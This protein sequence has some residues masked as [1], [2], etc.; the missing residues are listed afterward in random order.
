[1]GSSQVSATC[2]VGSDEFLI[3]QSVR[4]QLDAAGDPA[5]AVS[6]VGPSEFGPEHVLSLASPDLFG[7]PR[8]LVVHDVQD[9]GE[10]ER[11]VLVGYAREPMAD[12]LL[13]ALHTGG[14]KAR[15]F[16][17]AF[18]AAGGTV[19]TCVA[20]TRPAER[21][22][23]VADEIR[24]YGGQATAGAVRALVEAHGSDLRE[25]SSAARQLVGDTPGRIDGAAV[26]RFHSG[27]GETSGF[28]VAD[29]ALLGR[30]DDALALLTAALETGTAHVLV[31]SA[32]ASGLRDVVRVRA[33]SGT[34]AALARELGMPPWKVEK[35]QRIALGWNDVGLARAIDAVAVADGDV[36]G[37]AADV[38]YALQRAVLAVCG[39]HG[40]P[41][42]NRR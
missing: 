14:T 6:H 22:Q 29:A 17:K 10:A 42:A 37:A 19:T 41:G 21:M 18:A 35:A 11:D 2:I 31:S 38:D 3:A 15:G 28:A 8:A 36:K 5:I 12:L 23:F 24:A 4:A 9:L 26:A 1:M 13:L 16:P 30:G 34:P 7:E 27:R 32:L 25:L 20:L 40:G 39:A 33:R